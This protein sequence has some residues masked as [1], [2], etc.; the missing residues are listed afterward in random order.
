[1][2]KLGKWWEKNYLS[3]GN[4]MPGQLDHGKIPLANG[5]LDVIKSDSDGIFRHFVAITHF[6]AGPDL[7]S[8]WNCYEK[9]LKML[10]LVGSMY[11]HGDGANVG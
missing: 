6:R 2:K 10:L 8:P 9:K 4:P 11:C 7:K 5:P 1:M 3:F